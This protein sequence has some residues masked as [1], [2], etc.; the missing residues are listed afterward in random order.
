MSHLLQ[1]FT[2]KVVWDTPHHNMS[3]FKVA[4]GKSSWLA[5]KKASV[6]LWEVLNTSLVFVQVAKL[7][8]FLAVF[9]HASCELLF[10]GFGVVLSFKSSN[11]VNVVD[12]VLGQTF[13][14]LK[15][16]QE[17]VYFVSSLQLLLAAAI[18]IILFHQ[19]LE[20]VDLLLVKLELLAPVVD[21]LE[22]I[23]LVDL[24]KLLAFLCVEVEGLSSL[25]LTGLANVGVLAP[26]A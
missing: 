6:I 15:L 4:F 3:I 5:S 21:Q 19:R 23:V 16:F 8:K 25:V 11:V 18:L 26:D 14:N 22:L 1:S 9:N 13:T 10:A 2:H 20:I 17:I 12:L 24:W 7:F